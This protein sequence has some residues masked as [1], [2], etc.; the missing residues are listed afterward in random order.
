[1]KRDKGIISGDEAFRAL[2]FTVPCSSYLQLIENID[3]IRKKL[4][5]SFF[6]PH[7]QKA[8]WQYRRGLER[9]LGV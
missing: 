4:G 8:L 7:Y 5:H 2:F 9:S 1:M 3:R 6:L